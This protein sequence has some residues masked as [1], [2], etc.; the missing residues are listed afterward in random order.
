MAIIIVL[1]VGMNTQAFAQREFEEGQRAINV[2]ITR[3][4]DMEEIG[5]RGGLTHFINPDMRLGGD[6]TYWLIDTPKDVSAIYLEINA[7]FNYIFYNENDFLIYGIGSLGLH[8]WRTK[9]DWDDETHT[10]SDSDLGIGIGAGFE[11]NVGSFSLFA[12]P[13]IFLSG[14]DQTKLNIGARIYL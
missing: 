4:F 10:D 3:G 6:I 5:L 13:K 12:E 7:N 1:L 2:G 8:Y 11:Y 9:Y 14:Y